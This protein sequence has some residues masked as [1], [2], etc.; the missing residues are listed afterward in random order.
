MPLKNGEIRV[1]YRF[2]NDHWTA[3]V[4]LPGW[5]DGELVWKGKPSALHS[6]TQT[7]DLPL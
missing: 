2:N 5:M 4:M 3:T 6:G 7:L 1:G